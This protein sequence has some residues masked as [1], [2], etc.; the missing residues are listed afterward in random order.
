MSTAM[1]IVIA[2]LHSCICTQTTQAHPR[3]GVFVATVVKGIDDI[4]H[5]IHSSLSLSPL[6]TVG[7]RFL[8]VCA[9]VLLPCLRP[10]LL[11]TLEILQIVT[12]ISGV[13]NR[14]S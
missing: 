6:P 4:V 5:F 10:N 11:A 7:A 12:L 8:R 2:E 1:S 13:P 9:R 3:V 14:F